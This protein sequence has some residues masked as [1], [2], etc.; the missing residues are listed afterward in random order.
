MAFHELPTT[1]QSLRGSR[2][3]LHGSA[4]TFFGGDRSYATRDCELAQNSREFGSVH[5]NCTHTRPNPIELRERVV[6]T[7]EDR[8]GSDGQPAGLQ[9]PAVRELI[10]G[11]GATAVLAAPIRT[12]SIERSRLG[13]DQETHSRG[14][15]GTAATASP[16]GTMC[17]RILT[18]ALSEL[19]RSRR[20]RIQMISGVKSRRENAAKK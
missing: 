7:Y 13:A 12:I 19:V 3:A 5:N 16:N 1:C 8:R 20:L 4:V 9:G 15:P 14:G 2:R 17:P 11:V 10:D 6:R 18:E